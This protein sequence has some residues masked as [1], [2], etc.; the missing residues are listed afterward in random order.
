MTTMSNRQ[1]R[2]IA[3]EA[4]LAS[5][6]GTLA[7]VTVFWRDW[8]EFLFGWDPDHH[9][10]SAELAIIIGLACIAVVLGITARWQAVRWRRAAAAGRS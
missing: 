9:N 2:L 5:V 8:I 6:A 7:V 10:G 4:V 1:K 3:A